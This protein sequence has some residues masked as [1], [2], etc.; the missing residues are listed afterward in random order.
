M[1]KT[2][3]LLAVF[4]AVY[5]IA[6]P[7]KAF[8]DDEYVVELHHGGKLQGELKSAGS[9]QKY[10]S[11]KGIPYGKPPINELRL[12]PTVP[13]PGWKGI[14][15]ATSHGGTCLNPGYLLTPSQSGQEDCLY[16][17]VY[18]PDL[19]PEE[20][21]P[22]MFWIHG[23]AFNAGS[24]NSLIYGP[25]W[26]LKEDVIVVT[27]NYRLGLLG[28]FATGDKHS[29]GNYGA[30]DIVTALKWV[31]SNIEKFGGDKDRVTVFGES[32]GSALTHYM[33]LS[34]MSR[35]LFSRAIAQSGSALAPWS[36]QD[37]P[38]TTAFRIA[39]KLGL[40]A[41]TTEEIVD[42]IRKI[43]DL[44]RFIAV[45]ATLLT[46]DLPRGN[47]AFDYAPVVEPEDCDD[48]ERFLV[49][50]PIVTTT[51]GDIYDVPF[52]VGHNDAEALYN[53][54]ELDIYPTTADQYNNNSQ[55]LLPYEWHILPHTAAAD[56]IITHVKNMYFNGGKI[57]DKTQYA[58]YN[59]DRHF[60]Y[61]VSKTVELH[62]AAQKSPIYYY[63]FSFDGMLNYIKKIFVVLKY[64]GA[65][66]ADE[67]G[68]LWKMMHAPAPIIPGGKADIT[69][70]RMLRM[71]TNFAKFADPTPVIDDKIIT[72]KWSPVKGRQ[73]Y[74]DI[75]DE[76]VFGSEPFAERMRMWKKLD[77]KYN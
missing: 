29:C 44:S 66:H 54:R 69:K 4:T 73:E 52:M 41:T 7:Q 31:Q 35:G 59:T 45:T 16:L 6:A 32:A 76:L 33:M 48:E 12:R 57:G 67:L 65:M 60:S 50:P 36:Y 24:G 72:T 39:K 61:S 75:G 37:F 51:K 77:Q 34:K 13:H 58:T 15:N 47:L 3:F 62:S 42:E 63:V 71:W 56:D 38:K 53:V 25:E 43:D 10:V 30:K 22:V 28:W 74:M 49:E 17:N 20:K 1:F 26:L 11:F 19:N 46:L 55:W 5:V 27:I 21:Y 64:K 14:R 18:T 2:V 40:N 9:K 68:Y 8:A 70:S 23:G